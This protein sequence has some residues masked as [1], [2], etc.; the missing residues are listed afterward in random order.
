MNLHLPKALLLDL[1]DTILDD[2][3]GIERSWKGACAGSAR[4]LGTIDP[5]TLYQAIERTRVWFWSDSERH[6]RGRLDL[7]AAAREVVALALGE[8][9]AADA[10]LA[11]AIAERYRTR[12]AAGFEPFP[13]ALDT[14]RWL[15]QSGC[16][17]ALVTN[18][19]GEMQRGK[20]VR[21][22]LASLFDAILIEGELGFGKPDPRIYKQ[23]LEEL[24]VSA[25]DTW[26][27][28]DNL[29]W[30]VAQPQRIGMLGI[31][32]DARGA[33]VPDTSDVR[34][35]RVVRRLSDLRLQG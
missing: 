25:A 35:D 6:R 2:S 17:L 20:I 33:G 11:A 13:G 10:S 18:G 19:S 32:V 31:W 27:V 15:R 24:S 1:D 9:G 8:C 3:G 12:R 29:D 22:G 4:E 21:F 34:P 23:A 30:D 5:E 14:V 26:M 28:G 16:R 7:S